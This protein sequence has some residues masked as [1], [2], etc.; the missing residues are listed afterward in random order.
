MLEEKRNKI[1]NKQEKDVIKKEERN[2]N[3][4]T[5]T[6]KEDGNTSCRTESGPE[7]VDRAI[8]L[9]RCGLKRKP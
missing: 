1:N 8:A 4:W 7:G 5:D 6:E 9:C 2:R 3:H